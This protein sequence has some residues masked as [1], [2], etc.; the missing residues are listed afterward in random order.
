[1]F[2]GWWEVMSNLSFSGCLKGNEYFDGILEMFIDFYD[3]VI[4]CFCPQVIV[5]WTVGGC[6]EW[7]QENFHFKWGFW[8]NSI[9]KRFC[10][11]MSEN[12]WKTLNIIFEHPPKNGNFKWR[13]EWWCR[14]DSLPCWSNPNI[15]YLNY[16]YFQCVQQKMSI[17]FKKQSHVIIPQQWMTV[18]NEGVII[19]HVK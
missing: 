11:R 1:M 4:T 5:F 14:F 6:D 9:F 19:I 2:K 15:F 7:C 18:Q 10:G 8:V 17:F 16:S 12:W 13:G 3:F